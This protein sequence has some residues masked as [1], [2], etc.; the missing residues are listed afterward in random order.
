M[1][2][3]GTGVATTNSC[4]YCSQSVCAGKAGHRTTI[5]DS[6]QARATGSEPARGNTGQANNARA[7]EA[8]CVGAGKTGR[9]G[10]AR[11][12]C[13]CAREAGCVFATGEARAFNRNETAGARASKA[14]NATGS[15]SNEA[16]D[17]A[18]HC[19]AR[20]A[21][22]CNRVESN[23]GSDDAERSAQVNEGDWPDDEAD[24]EEP[25]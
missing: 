10:G 25:G 1:C 11:K 13:T 15:D 24:A 21:A 22:A 6:G 20:N 14:R 19:Q 23:I 5:D 9:A 8:C 3:E 12:A 17:T 16:C 4:D 2:E 7:R 18:G